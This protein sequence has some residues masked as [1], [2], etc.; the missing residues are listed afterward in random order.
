MRLKLARRIV[1][2]RVGR[3]TWD[4][5]QDRGLFG[6]AQREL[7]KFYRTNT[8]ALRLLIEIQRKVHFWGSDHDVTPLLVDEV[9]GDGMTLCQMVPL[10]TRPDYYVIRI[11]G[12]W[13]KGDEDAFYDDGLEQIYQAIEDQYGSRDFYCEDCGE[14]GWNDS[15]CSCN[16]SREWPALNLGAGTT[17]GELYFPT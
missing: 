6:Q 3:H 8:A 9:L 12:S 11:D 7:A 14:S 2:G 5:A 4:S 15:D 13:L 16:E 10:N 17:W 1:R